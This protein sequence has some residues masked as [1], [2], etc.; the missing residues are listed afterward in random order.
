MIFFLS[1][2]ELLKQYNWTTVGFNKTLLHLVDRESLW[3]F[4]RNFPS[5]ARLAEGNQNRLAYSLD[6]APRDLFPVGLF[7]DK[8]V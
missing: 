7:Y 3:M 6:L 8:Y 4:W 5:S 1:A 2:L